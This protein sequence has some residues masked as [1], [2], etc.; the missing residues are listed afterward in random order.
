[1][2]QPAPTTAELVLR[3]A[4]LCHG[5]PVSTP[6][7][8]DVASALDDPAAVRRTT[9]W[10]AAERLGGLWV[11]VLLQHRVTDE[12]AVAAH[13]S[14]QALVLACEAAACR[15]SEVLAA[16]GVDVRLGKGIAA[17]NLDYHDPAFRSTVDVDALVPREQLPTALAALEAAGYR[18]SQPAPRGSWEQRYAR[19]VP[20]L[21]P[22]GL[23]I[24][25]HLALATGYFGRRLPTERVWSERCTFELGGVQCGALAPPA[26]LLW[27]CYAA[28]LNRGS[29]QR[30]LRDAAQLVLVRSVDW[31]A[32]VDL[33]ASGD[34]SAVLAA[35]ATA[36]VS[37]GMLPAE[38]PFAQWAQQVRP[39]PRAAKAL[40]FAELGQSHGWLADARSTMLALGPIDAARFLTEF[41]VP[42]AAHRRS[43]PRTLRQRV[44]RFGR[45]ARMRP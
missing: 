42:S 19:A 26:R 36:A 18:R 20:L 24:D 44:R 9:T 3:R 37:E 45:F 5:L 12:P 8:D 10:A 35:A 29:S 41:V 17:A 11:G 21:S 31:R 13:R 43:R 34:G 27:A 14:S 16:A 6:P 15:M 23:E 25:L 32:A 33:A 40:A 39:S 7:A 1:M 28:G 4:V 2:N 22:D 38:H 30:Y